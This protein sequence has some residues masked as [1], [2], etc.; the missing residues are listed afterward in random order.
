MKKQEA[1]TILV[2]IA[3]KI[4]IIE[5][6]RFSFL[7]DQ[8]K[9][10]Y[11]IQKEKEYADWL[12][13]LPDGFLDRLNKQASFQ[14]INLL[15]KDSFYPTELF[16][17]VEWV[18][19]L[20]TLEKSLAYLSAYKQSLFPKVKELQK[21]LQYVVDNDKN[22][23]FR[24]F[25]DRT[26]K[27]NVELAK[28]EVQLNYG[29][30]VDLDN[31][32]EKWNN[33]SEPT[34]VV[35]LSEHKLD[36]SAKIRQI[37]K[38]DDSNTESY[39]F[40]QCLETL[41][42]AEK[43]IKQNSKW[44]LIDD[45]KE[46]WNQIRETQIKAI[47]A[48]YPVDL[49][50]Y[51][52]E[53]VAKFLPNL[54]RNFDNLSAIWECSNDFLQ[55]MCHIPEEDIELIKT[56]ISQMMSQGKE[57]YYPKLRVDNLSSLEFK[58]LGLLKFYK[59]YPKDREARE[60]AFLEH[61]ESLKIKLE[62][63][64]ALAPNRFILNFLSEQQRKEWLEE[65]KGLYTA[66]NSFLTA[67]DQ[68]DILQFPAY[69]ERELKADF[70]ENSAT[71]HALIEAL[72]G[73][74]KI[75]TPNDLPDLI[76]DKVKQ[77][78]INRE[79]LGVT[80]RS[81]QEFGAQY[82][83]FY[84]NVLLGDEMGLGKT[85]QAISVANHLFQNDQQHT[86]VVC[87]LSVLE[88]WNREVQ[89]WSQLPTFLYRGSDRQRTFDKWKSEGGVLLTNY[90]QAKA[91]SETMAD[92]VFDFLV[93]D[94]AH[95]IK[96]P[97]TKRTIYT[98][99]LSKLAQY[100]LFMSGTPLENRL[101]E[102]KHLIKLLNVELGKKLESRYW[103]T[104]EFKT[105][106]STVYLRRKRE[107]VLDELPEMEVIELW[108]RFSE[109]QQLFYDDAVRDG[110]SGMMR[111]RRAA[112]VGERSKKLLQ[113]IDICKEA[114]ENGQ[115]VL[116]FSFFKEGV[117][118]RLQEELPNVAPVMILGSIS[119]AQRQDI[120]DEFSKDPNQTVLLSQI[121]AGGV[122]LNI[123]AANIVILCEPQW[124]PSTEQQAISRVYRMGQL[125]DV[126]VYR[127]LTEDSIDES[128]MALLDEKTALFNDFAND[129]SIAEAFEQRENFERDMSNESRLRQKVFE[130]EKKRLETKTLSQTSAVNALKKAE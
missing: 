11:F 73:S 74:K 68:N 16:S 102:M 66:Y 108:S 27:H 42:L 24:L 8:L 79:G 56:I 107:E 39:L 12:R 104:K 67:D 32:L 35:A 91:L 96:N 31:R 43:F 92:T 53:R 88:N 105:Q 123:Q 60:K 4:E 76:V 69:S 30:L 116:V 100:K 103:T 59:D 98:T 51:A 64:R 78:N 87:P 71:F 57:H 2:S 3:P 119:P 28:K 33:F 84:R 44:K 122:G 83:L 70:V 15:L 22:S 128:M 48:S 6:E 120:I 65:E 89:K 46:V 62:K 86:I 93:V 36:Y 77:V 58:L 125:R 121:D 38:I 111:M 37:L 110:I 109:E 45:V 90:E 75:Y 126:V 9:E 20:Y 97:E 23:L 21:N 127:L 114:R 130:M 95:Y 118:Y 25:Q 47:E 26:I 7:E 61:I 14:D 52:D 5:S 41:A 80:M 94:E 106:L 40:R 13:G 18:K 129:S 124:K 19:M 72:T 54:S 85:I 55:K 117:L 82:I 10:Q 101:T 81:Y 49:L 17:N 1:R 34:A 63:I 112:F 99:L 29:L 113:I 115:K 50:G